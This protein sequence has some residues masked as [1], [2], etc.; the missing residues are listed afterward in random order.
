MPTYDYKCEAN[1]RVVE[2][3]HSLKE[4]IETWGQLCEKADIEPGDTPLD[5]PVTRL[6]TGGS[7]NSV[8]E[9]PR[10]DPSILPK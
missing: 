1:Q 8:G 2:V 10:F 5:S 7:F 4:V 3:R 6:I 9:L